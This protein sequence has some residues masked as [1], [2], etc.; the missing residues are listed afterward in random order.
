PANASKLRTFGA[1]RRSSVGKIGPS[2]RSLVRAAVDVTSLAGAK[3][4]GEIETRLL[5]IGNSCSLNGPAALRAR[6]LCMMYHRRNYLQHVYQQNYSIREINH[7]GADPLWL[8]SRTAQ[9]R[10]IRCSVSWRP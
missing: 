1:A 8:Q 4:G 10:L 2:S 6:L 3:D 7:L 9:F 5:F